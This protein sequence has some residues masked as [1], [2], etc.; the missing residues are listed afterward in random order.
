MTKLSLLM[1]INSLI[2]FSRWFKFNQRINSNFNQHLNRKENMKTSLFMTKLTHQR[3]QAY[4]PL[5]HS[6]PGL[7]GCSLAQGGIRSFGLLRELGP[8]PFSPCSS[9]S[10][11]P[12]RLV[13]L[14]RENSCSTG[15]H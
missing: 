8:Q 6:A 5:T 3:I 12:G 1:Q 9:E 2:K 11:A 13:G 10:R 14:G 7:P 4:G 15:P